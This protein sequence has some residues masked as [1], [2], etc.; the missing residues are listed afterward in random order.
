ML[1]ISA[2]HIQSK[3]QQKLFDQSVQ[4]KTCLISIDANAFIATTYVEMEWYNPKDQ[5]VEGY[6]AFELNRGQVITNFQLELNGKFR[7]GSIEERWKANQAYSRI[8]GKRIDP[9]ILQM[10]W[11]NHYSLR[12]YPIPAKGSRKIN[13]TITQMMEAEPNRLT[14]NLPMHFAEHTGIFKLDIKIDEPAL[15]PLANAGF[16]QDQ[17]FYPANGYSMLTMQEKNVTLNKPISFSLINP[18]NKPQACIFNENGQPYFVMRL[19]P[20]FSGYADK[21]PGRLT[22][23]WDVSGSSKTRNLDKE[24]EFLYSYIHANEIKNSEIILFNQNIQKSLLYETGKDDFR[25]IKNYLLQYEYG[26]S[27]ELGNLDFSQTKADAILIFSDGINAIGNTLPDAATVPVSCVVSSIQNNTSN[28]QLMIGT[29]GGTLIDLNSTSLENAVNKIATGE[30]YLMKCRADAITINESFPIRINKP[31]MLSGTIRQTCNLELV[32][33]NSN[34]DKKIENIY[35]SAGENC[36]RNV[37]AKIRML[38]SYDS[39]MYDYNDYYG[40]QNMVV[41]GLN[42]KVVTP[43]SSFLVLERIED[44]INY[45]IAPPKELEEKCADLN[46]VY[47]TEYKIR[48][49]KNFTEQDDLQAVVNGYNNRIRWWDPGASLIDLSK[50]AQMA[51]TDIGKKAEPGNNIN[52]IAFK[53]VQNQI[54]GSANALSEVVVTSAIGVNRQLRAVSSSSQTISGAQLNVVNGTDF[55]DALAGKVAGLQV[56]SQSAMALGSTSE[57]RIRGMSGFNS[58]SKILYVVDGT[59]L[60]DPNDINLNEIENVTVLQGVRAAALFGP[61][62]ADGAI[63]IERKKARKNY[64]YNYQ[65]AEYNINSVEEVEYMQEIRKAS[66]NE[67]WETYLNLE[68]ENNKQPGFYFD[69][70]DYFLEKGMIEKGKS[71]LY[72]GLELCNGN[73]AGLKAAAYLLESHKQFDFAIDMYKKIIAQFPENLTIQRDLALCYFQAENWQEAVNTYY[74]IILARTGNYNIQKE[75]ELAL[76]EMNAVI[77]LH[78]DSLDI[79]FINQNLIKVLPLDLRIVMESN[80]GYTNNFKVTEPNSTICTGQNPVTKKG[81]KLSY[82]YYGTY[83]FYGADEYII[84]NGTPGRYRVKMDLYDLYSNT[85]DIPHY[86]RILSYRNFQKEGQQLQIQTI[87]VDNQ[88]GCVELGDVKL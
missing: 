58:K 26:G 84:K 65:W 40:W 52:N 75:K 79:S 35:L 7:E 6:Q 32:Y 86:I 62:A 4:L 85:Q 41:F 46:Y 2:L 74:K 68:T 57:I 13:F 50:P 5:E 19:F 59:V 63:I 67:I 81:G 64:Q 22:V 72:N 29:R 21:K 12:I 1:F 11:Q 17:I 70:A 34:S 78:K 48:S 83:N 82:T 42:E 51:E 60:Y 10:D 24:L 53:Q 3:A 87:C 16:L 43:Q 37:Y 23:Y 28:L 55:N 36:K 47:K 56:R 38:K 8:V 14:Y 76:F 25:Q 80:F 20:D 9:A 18:A 77:A 30:N 49:L 31:I 15:K 71:V 27:T 44:Y 45:K 61:D 69:M 88:Y 39:L 33:G 73:I 54:G 66:Y